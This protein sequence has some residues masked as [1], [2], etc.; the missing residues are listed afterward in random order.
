[1]PL[2][3]LH[4]CPTSWFHWGEDSKPGARRMQ[5]EFAEGIRQAFFDARVPGIEELSWITVSVGSFA[6]LEDDG[7]MII[8]VEGMFDER[9]RTREVRLHLGTT[10]LEA[11]KRIMPKRKIEVIIDP[12]FDW[13]ESG[14]FLI[15]VP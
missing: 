10:L 3:L 2:V 6:A 8:K 13:R 4:N 12:P 14:V 7:A 11:A 1:M 15:H 9:G 5:R